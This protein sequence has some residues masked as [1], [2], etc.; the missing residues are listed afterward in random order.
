M[1]ER[2]RTRRTWISYMWKR[3]DWRRW[4]YTGNFSWNTLSTTFR[5]FSWKWGSGTVLKVLTQASSTPVS[6]QTQTK[7]LSLW[8]VSASHRVWHHTPLPSGLRG[9]PGKGNVCQEFITHLHLTTDQIKTWSVMRIQIRST[10]LTRG[11]T[12]RKSATSPLT[13]STDLATYSTLT[14]VVS[15]K[16][17]FWVFQ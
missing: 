16:T 8:K 14:I 11:D 15:V 3:S 2:V 10:S 6:L 4:T 13:R 1:C 17:S 9:V 7:T 5:P 12:V